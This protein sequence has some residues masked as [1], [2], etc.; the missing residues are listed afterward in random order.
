MGDAQPLG[1]GT[2][3]ADIG[4]GAAGAWPACG[5]TLIIKLQRDPN[6]IATGGRRQ[7]RH[8][9]RIDPARH[10]DGHS[11]ASQRRQHVARAGGQ[12]VKIEGK[13]GGHV[14]GFR[15]RNGHAAGCRQGARPVKPGRAPPS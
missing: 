6:R 8:H 3:V 12:R 5:G 4:P 9:R 14:H 1:H 7:R 10:G 11:P 15:R 13:G 2:R